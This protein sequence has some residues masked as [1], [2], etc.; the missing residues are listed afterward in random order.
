MLVATQTMPS[1]PELEPVTPE[2][3]VAATNQD[4]AEKLRMPKSAETSELSV[5]DIYR[6]AGLS[7]V[8]IYGYTHN[9]TSVKQG[10]AFFVEPRGAVVTNHHVLQGVESAEIKL[11]SGAVYSVEG[12]LAEDLANDLI[13]VSTAAPPL[14]VRP[15]TFSTNVPQVGE[16]IVVIGTPRGLAQT[17]SDGIVSSLRESTTIGRLIQI[18]APISHGSSGSPVLNM[19]GEVIGV[20]QGG[21][22]PIIGQDRTIVAQAQ[23]LNWCIPI[24]KVQRLSPGITYPIAQIAHSQRQQRI[25]SAPAMDPE[26]IRRVEEARR[27]QIEENSKRAEEKT[28]RD[29]ELLNEARSK[30][31]RA[32]HD[33]SFD[34]YAKSFYGF[35]S[36][37]ARCAS[38][39]HIECMI[40]CLEMMGRIKKKVGD[41]ETAAVY[42]AEA[43]KL[44]AQAS[45]AR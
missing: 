34:R 29:E 38:I 35:D 24:E 25:A 18:T 20:A 14:D 16:K 42:D 37:R 8:V 9:R 27:R 19:K 44:R 32:Y 10:T 3:T 23:N 2:R 40:E 1:S 7:V 39:R 30:V 36:A 31:D 26:P 6:T 28:R 13:M 43:A 41:N 4:N 15:L 22:S 5:Q 21:M 12:V 11:N 33:L 17:V 45:T